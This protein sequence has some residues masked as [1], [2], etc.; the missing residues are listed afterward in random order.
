MLILRYL[1]NWLKLE[2]VID[3]LYASY[4]IDIDEIIREQYKNKGNWEQKLTK[5]WENIHRVW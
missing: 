1:T 2:A 3:Q 5:R 4:E